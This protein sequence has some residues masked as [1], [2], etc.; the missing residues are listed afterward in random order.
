MVFIKNRLSILLLITVTLS[1]GFFYA[2]AQAAS[3]LSNWYTTT[4]QKESEKTTSTVETEVWTTFKL[5]SSFI[6]EANENATTA[7]ENFRNKQVDE[8][9]A[10]IEALATDMKKQI[11]QTVTE[12][13][14]ENL[15]E[16]IESRNIEDEIEEDV[17][18]ILVEILGK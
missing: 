9:K 6:V 1:S 8:S 2:N 10:N 17:E 13:E 11:N 14:K 7:I 3:T 5:V 12:L 16:Y 4:F 15:D 18:R